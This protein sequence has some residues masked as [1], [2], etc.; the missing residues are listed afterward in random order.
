LIVGLSPYASRGRYPQNAAYRRLIVVRLG[1]LR[2]PLRQERVD[3][4]TAVG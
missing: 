4:F 2:L 3:T 1:E